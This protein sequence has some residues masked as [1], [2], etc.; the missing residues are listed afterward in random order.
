MD[1]VAHVDLLAGCLLA[2]LVAEVG[3]SLR[4]HARR[5]QRVYLLQ[6]ASKLSQDTCGLMVALINRY[7]QRCFTL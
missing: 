2:V 4:L 7:I 3:I 1:L 5:Q 6:L